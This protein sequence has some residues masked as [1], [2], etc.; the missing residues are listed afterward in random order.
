MG[1]AE[2]ASDLFP[3]I[4]TKSMTATSTTT[5]PANRTRSQAEAALR[6]ASF[7]AYGGRRQK[8][9]GSTKMLVDVRENFADDIST[10]GENNED[11]RFGSERCITPAMVKQACAEADTVADLCEILKMY[12]VPSRNGGDSDDN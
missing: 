7:F 11:L 9:S 6:T 4:S 10:E 3:S 5:K 8:S 12:A 1:A 2:S